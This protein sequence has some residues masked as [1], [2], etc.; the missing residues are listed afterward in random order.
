MA[1][2]ILKKVP[3][4]DVWYRFDD[5]VCLFENKDNIVITG[6]RDFTSYGDETLIKVIKG[7]YYDEDKDKNGEVIGYDYDTYEELK[8]LTGKDWECATIRGYSQSDWQ[9]VYYVPAEVSQDRIDE[10]ENFYM[11]KISEFNVLEDGEE[12]SY[13][14]FV[15]DDVVWK[16]KKEICEYLGANPDDVTVLEPDGY[17]KVYNWKEIE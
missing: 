16:G 2:T 9:Y 14:A 11:G 10:I 5:E 7:D 17:T 12:Y 1:K 13:T 4:E 8:K 3:D 6:N 15:P